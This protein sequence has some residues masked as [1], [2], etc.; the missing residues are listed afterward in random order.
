LVWLCESERYRG[1][2]LDNVLVAINRRD[3]Q[4]WI[5]DRKAVQLRSSTLRNREI[6]VKLFIEWL[7]TLE[8]GRVRTVESTPYKT[9]KLISPAAEK[10]KPGYIPWE[11]IVSLLNAYHNESERCLAH[12][13]FDTGLRISEI[14]RLK[15][16]DL[17][18][19]NLHASGQKYYAMRVP[20]SKGRG[21]GIKE[22]TALISAPVLAR[23]SRYHNSFEYRFSPFW[24]SSNPNKPAFLQVNGNRLCP[25]NVRAQ[26]DLAALRAGLDQA[27]FCPHKLRHGAAFSML[28]SELG[29][30]YFDKLF[31]V[32]QLFG[33]KSITTTE[34]YTVI[35]PAV[36]AKLNANSVI[37]EKYEEAKQILDATYLPSARH[38][39]A[40]GHRNS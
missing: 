25:R 36:L 22:R 38:N 15:I 13:L 8:A 39:E 31:L 30:D 32:Q 17:P 16:Q 40:R 9:D 26:M 12:T 2:S 14:Q 28:R 1:L 18:K 27:L 29:K 19:A 35:P 10:R 23:I 21:G 7:T 6:A 3:L 37:V 34:I 11:L 20:G 24:E 5:L 33:H 4:E